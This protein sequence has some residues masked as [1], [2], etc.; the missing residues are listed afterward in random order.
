MV[1]KSQFIP[2]FILH[3]FHMKVH[4]LSNIAYKV[5]FRSRI[6]KDAGRL[7][8]VN[9]TVPA[10]KKGHFYPLLQNHFMKMQFSG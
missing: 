7:S 3:A 5:T 10:G 2:F 4:L 1:L 9:Y 6:I 8:V